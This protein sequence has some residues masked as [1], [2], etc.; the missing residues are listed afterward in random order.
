LLTP[1][2]IVLWASTIYLRYHYCIDLIAGASLA[3]GVYW[4]TAGKQQAADDFSDA[5]ASVPGQR[6]PSTSSD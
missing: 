4:L 6:V 1:M 2:M 5:L 3:L